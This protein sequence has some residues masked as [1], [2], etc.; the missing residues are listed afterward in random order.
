[1]IPID[2]QF[3][4][5]EKEWDLK[6]LYGDLAFAKGKPLTPME[7]LHLRGLLCGH[8]PAEMADKLN[9]NP[10]GV[11]SDLCATVY[12]YVKALLEKP[13]ERIENWRKI[14]EW[15][16]EAGYRCEVSTQVPLN[17]LLPGNSVVNITN[18]AIE[19]NQLVIVINLRIPTSQATD[20][21]EQR[22][23]QQE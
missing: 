1:M 15:L 16:D 21:L 4:Q 5:A 18:V 11:E 6:T 23:E 17:E 7:K 9:K 2:K 8:S 20:S 13:C 10:K 3:T 22:S 14:A 19:H 12:R